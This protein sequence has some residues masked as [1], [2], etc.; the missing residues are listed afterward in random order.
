MNSSASEEAMPIPIPGLSSQF[1]GS[2]STGSSLSL[3][4]CVFPSSELVQS[5]SVEPSPSA[6]C[7][8]WRP[9]F[10]QLVFMKLV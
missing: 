2:S 5:S 1:V 4:C 7:F 8:E 3:S 9:V 10:L 6:C